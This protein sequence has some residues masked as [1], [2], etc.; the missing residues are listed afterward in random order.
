MFVS[1]CQKEKLESRRMVGVTRFVRVPA[2][3]T[4]IRRTRSGVTRKGLLLPSA[5]A[6]RRGRMPRSRRSAPSF[7]TKESKPLEAPAQGDRA[8][9]DRGGASQWMRTVAPSIRCAPGSAWNRLPIRRGRVPWSAPETHFCR[10]QPSTRALRR[11]SLPCVRSCR[12]P[13]ISPVSRAHGMLRCSRRAR[14][15]IAA[16]AVHSVRRHAGQRRTNAGISWP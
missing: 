7:R 6:E 8:H 13:A 2:S 10:A 12:K 11:A 15:P 1:V 3:T 14:C 4:G 5:R 16:R 9:G